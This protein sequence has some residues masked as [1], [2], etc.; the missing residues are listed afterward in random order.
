[1]TVS[2]AEFKAVL[3]RFPTGVTVVTTCDGERPAGLTVNAFASISLDP[4]LVMVSIDRRSHLHDIVARVGFFAANILGAHQQE[5]S[6]RFAGQTTDRNERFRMT[7]WRRG[8]TGAPLL[9][10][11][12]GWVECRVAAIYPA[13]DHSIFL[14]Q[15]EALGAGPGDP[16]VYYRAGYGAFTA[17]S[18]ASVIPAR[19]E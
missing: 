17:E 8:H 16:L 11:A 15:V 1:M 2:D 3:G 7:A 6:R 9:V 12:I 5:T 13:G 4:P 14:G 19:R 10:E 18:D